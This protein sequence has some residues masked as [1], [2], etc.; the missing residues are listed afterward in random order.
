MSHSIVKHL[1]NTKLIK[2][3]HTNI[4]SIRK[5]KVNQFL[6]K[7]YQVIEEGDDVYLVGKPKEVKQKDKPKEGKVAA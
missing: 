5:D 4:I 6:L 1:S 7:G 3:E 2:H